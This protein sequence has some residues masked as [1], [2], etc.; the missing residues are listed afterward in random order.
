MGAESRWG[1]FE[2][3]KKNSWWIDEFP[4]R[5]DVERRSSEDVLYILWLEQTEE[6]NLEQED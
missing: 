6:E 2:D 5:A 3:I 4:G 1:I